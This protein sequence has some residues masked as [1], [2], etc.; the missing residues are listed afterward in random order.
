MSAHSAARAQ[1]PHPNIT[2]AAVCLA[3][4]VVPLS[5]TGASVAL[6]DIG[7][8]MNAD[9][10]PLQWV[11]HA[12]N[13]VSASFMLATGSLA[14]LFGRR[15][16]FA[17]G[18]A[19][20]SV[21]SL[22]CA[23]ANNIY[24]LDV[25]R[26]LV[27]LGTAAVITGGSAILAGFEGPARVRAFAVFGTA[28]GCGLAFGP[29]TSGLLTGAFGW[30]AAFLSHAILSAVVLLAIPFLTESRDPNAGRV[31]WAGTSTFT[32]GLFLLTLGLVE[33]PQLGWASGTVLA[34]LGGFVV[35]M[36]LFVVAERMQRRPMF[37]L[38]LL[39]EA[40]FIAVC[41]VP[42]GVAFGFVSLL[43]L[44][45]SYFIGAKGMSAGAAGATMLLMTVPVLV[46]PM[47]SNRLVRRGVST[48]VV[49]SASLLSLAIGG[50]WLALIMDADTRVLT[51]AAPLLVIGVGQG[52]S[53]GLADGVAIGTV[54]PGRS[55]MAAGMFNTMRLAG[56]AVA[57]AALGAVLVSVV[58]GRL[59]SG[60]TRFAELSGADPQS[61]ANN[62][63]SG[64]L[65]AVTGP[66]FDFLAAG[67]TEGLRAVL[68]V[69]AGLCVV[70]AAV[71]YLILAE[72]RQVTPSARAAMPEPATARP[73]S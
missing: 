65:S 13:V 63:A 32:L 35:L 19:L 49:L 9:L 45:P 16:L 22:G 28:V 38:S 42:V 3:V 18:A 7:R 55:G 2:L 62:V 61:V 47:I 54:E 8:D 29:S 12:Y 56:E 50:A 48:R 66:A 34:L 73:G 1:L 58:A 25:M 67:Y 44:L 71:I 17:M 31:D 59:T 53:M 21:S 14:D 15:R 5:L 60:A 4:L 69:A 52:L 43:V 41:V 39:R 30:R 40:R 26:G 33:G 68:F 64:D 6:P 10:V 37:D 72:R 11:V 20:F 57:V 24:L 36:V 51:L 70:G 46:V 23:L 27:G